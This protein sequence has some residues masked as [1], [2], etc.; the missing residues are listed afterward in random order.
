MTIQERAQTILSEVEFR[1]WWFV[2]EADRFHV[3]FWAKDNFTGA[4]AIQRGR[5]WLI[6]PE[7]ADSAIV[8]T[9]WAAIEAAVIHEAREDFKY[10][11]RRVVGPHVS[12][13]ALWRVARSVDIKQEA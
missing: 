2:V 5:P 1:D 13:E 10:K 3:A 12:V 4:E 6:W 9:A 7:M 11:G 8:F